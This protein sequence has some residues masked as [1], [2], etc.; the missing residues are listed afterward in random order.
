[1]NQLFVSFFL[2]SGNKTINPSG[3][4]WKVVFVWFKSFENSIKLH[5]TLFYSIS[6]YWSSWMFVWR[7]PLQLY[8]NR[9]NTFLFRD[10]V[11]EG[12]SYKGYISCVQIPP[13]EGN[14]IVLSL[15]LSIIPPTHRVGWVLIAKRMG[16]SSQLGVWMP[17]PQRKMVLI[18]DVSGRLPALYQAVIKPML[19]RIQ[20]SDL[21]LGPRKPGSSRKV[22]RSFMMGG[23]RSWA[24][25]FAADGKAIEVFWSKGLYSCLHLECKSFSEIITN[26]N[27]SY[28]FLFT[29]PC[30]I[31]QII[32]CS[33]LPFLLLCY[34]GFF[35]VMFVY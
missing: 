9:R 23:E 16:S 19:E 1:M 29:F 11:C 4:T 24:N 31:R 35:Q 27:C 30:K 25:C 28:L 17:G 5:E 10:G 2:D 13:A 15:K 32:L 22:E 26:S 6:S 34:Y 33:S 3:G 20:E 7:L 14:K 21:I 12:F 8:L 18:K